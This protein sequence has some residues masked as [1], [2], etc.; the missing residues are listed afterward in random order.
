MKKP[1]CHYTVIARFGKKNSNKVVY[2]GIEGTLTFVLSELRS[3]KKK[4]G[5]DTY[6]IESMNS[7]PSLKEK[8]KQRSEFI[9]EYVPMKDQKL[10]QK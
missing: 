7:F 10:C 3:I 9:S 4:E 2:Y 6:I 5:M 1:Y 8:P